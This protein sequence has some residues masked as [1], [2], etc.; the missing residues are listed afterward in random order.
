MLVANLT[1]IVC[2]GAKPSC[3]LKLATSA[4][5]AVQSALLAVSGIEVSKHDGIIEDDVEKTIINL[6]KVGTLGMS[7]TDDVILN[8][9]INKC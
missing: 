8:I 5:A 7:V 3:A 4:S 2:D 9:M 1:G 6:A